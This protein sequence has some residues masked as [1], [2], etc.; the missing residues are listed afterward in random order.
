MPASPPG[1]LPNQGLNL[2]LLHLLHLQVGSLPLVPPG[3]PRCVCVCVCVC[4]SYFSR[5]RLFVT[6]W[7]GKPR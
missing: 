4:L 5:V 1:D 3:R 7:A 6:A 2:R